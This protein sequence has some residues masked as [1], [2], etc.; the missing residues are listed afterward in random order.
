MYCT[1]VRDQCCTDDVPALEPNVLTLPN[2][3][4]HRSRGGGDIIDEPVSIH[5]GLLRARML[6]IECVDGITPNQLW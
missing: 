2:R 6:P 5:C 1:T 3:R 4:E